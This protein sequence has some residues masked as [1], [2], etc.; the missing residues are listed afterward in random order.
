MTYDNAS[1]VALY[2]GASQ[3]LRYPNGDE[4]Q[5]F[6]VSFLVRDWSGV[7]CPDGVEGSELRFWSLDALPEDVMPM[8]RHTLADFKNYDGTFILSEDVH[9]D[10]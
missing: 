4:I 10:K 3:Q 6:A 8:H 2:S 1:P 9:R 7:P 5:G